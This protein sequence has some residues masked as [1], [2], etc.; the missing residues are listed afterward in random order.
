MPKFN[1]LNTSKDMKIKKNIAISE[2]GFAFDPNSGDSFSLNPIATEIFDLLK[3]GNSEKE[4]NT[5]VL[6]KYE[7]DEFTFQRNYDDF[8]QMLGHYNFIED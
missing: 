2:T 5:H 8:I 6:D 3:S 7:I 4:I 1:A